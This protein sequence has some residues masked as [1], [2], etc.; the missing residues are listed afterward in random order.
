MRHIVCTIISFITIKRHVQTHSFI[1]SKLKFAGQLAANRRQT[2]SHP[3]LLFFYF[4]LYLEQTEVK[5]MM[6]FW[7]LTPHLQR[8]R[9]CDPWVFLKVKQVKLNRIWMIF[10]SL[11]PSL[12]SHPCTQRSD[13]ITCSFSTKARVTFT[14]S[15]MTSLDHSG[16]Q[17]HLSYKHENLVSNWFSKK[18]LFHCYDIWCLHH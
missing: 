2:W 10:Y 17:R 3:R 1:I 15:V 6:S 12:H 4:T 14:R 11:S 13:S 8:N 9:A 16:A 7:T 5:D 18:G